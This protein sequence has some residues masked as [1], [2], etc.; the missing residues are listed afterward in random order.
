MPSL[1]GSVLCHCEAAEG[2]RSNLV[3][4]YEI[5]APRQVGASNGSG[6]QL[7]ESSTYGNWEVKYEDKTEFE[8]TPLPGKT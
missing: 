4:G 8:E 5:A 2:S 1:L 6:K 7:D 3:E